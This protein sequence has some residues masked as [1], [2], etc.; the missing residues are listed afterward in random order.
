MTKPLTKLILSIFNVGFAFDLFI[1]KRP[2]DTWTAPQGAGS[3]LQPGEVPTLAYIM[4][5]VLRWHVGK[6]II[7]YETVRMYVLLWGSMIIVGILILFH[8]SY[9]SE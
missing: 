1:K 9:V 6:G 3:P 4:A 2:P 7:I 8:K 5:C